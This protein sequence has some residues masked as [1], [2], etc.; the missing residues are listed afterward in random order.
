LNTP[1]A[2]VYKANYQPRSK[3]KGF[4]RVHVTGAFVRP[5]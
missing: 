5:S 3:V 4:E 1:E 2:R